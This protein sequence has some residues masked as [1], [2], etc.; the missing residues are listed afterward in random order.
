MKSSE[1]LRVLA[2]LSTSQWGMVTTAQAAA[3]GVTRLDLSRL[4]VA[5]H[6]ERVAHG[7]YRDAGAP[8][9]EFESL[10]AAWLAADPSP[11][12][13]ARLRDLADGVVI[14]GTS[15]ASLHEVGDLPAARHEFSTPV[16]RQTQR[17]DVVYRQRLRGPDDVTIAHGLPV[18]TIERTLTD[19]VA[20]R[21]DL[22]LVADALRDAA[23]ARRLDTGRLIELLG[24]LAAR[25]GHRQNDGTALFN[26]LATLA[27]LD[28]ASLAHAIGTSE[29]LSELVAANSLARFNTPEISRAL[30]G[31]ATEIALRDLNEAIAQSVTQSLAPALEAFAASTETLTTPALEAAF[32]VLAERISLDLP[33]RELLGSFGEQWAAALAA[34]T[35]ASQV[36]I[37]KAL[38][39]PTAASLADLVSTGV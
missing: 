14:M 19:L 1:A 3:S 24:P 9:D 27:G 10:R 4:T 34:A 21:T 36:D 30:L 37:L 39:L 25:N 20:A 8:A 5:G 31:P 7:V 29:T 15:A 26:H 22:S 17:P 28:S 32:T 35:G 2:G 11:T 33:T 18:T 6:L 13:E 38:D 23:R 16:R 12:A